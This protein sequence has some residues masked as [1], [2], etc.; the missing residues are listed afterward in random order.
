MKL[1]AWHLLGPALLY[2]GVHAQNADD[3][4]Q[5]LCC[6][7]VPK[8]FSTALALLSVAY[9]VMS[10]GSNLEHSVMLACLVLGFK[11]LTLSVS[12]DEPK[13]YYVALVTCMMLL[14]IYHEMIGR[15]Y[16]V[17]AYGFLGAN[18][19]ARLCERKTSAANAIRDVAISHFIFYFTK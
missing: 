11:G 4:G 19:A 13:D 12:P 16:M 6:L 10:A 14:V 18:V 8:N 9:V 5:R 3:V 15:K 17:L 1:E 2:F 7:Q